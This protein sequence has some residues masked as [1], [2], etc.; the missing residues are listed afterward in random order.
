MAEYTK[1]VR[2]FTDRSKDKDFV[3][4]QAAI[5]YANT[6]LRQGHKVKIYDYRPPRRYID[7]VAE[8][9]EDYR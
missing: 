5:G 7:H 2:D 8:H 3:D 4:P 1:T 9:E 6:L